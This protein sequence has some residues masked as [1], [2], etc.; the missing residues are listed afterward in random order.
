MGV[1][2]VLGNYKTNIVPHKYLCK[3]YNHPTLNNFCKISFS[4]KDL[5]WRGKHSFIVFQ[6]STTS[7]TWC[8]F[9]MLTRFLF[10]KVYILFA[11]LI[12]TTA[13]GT[14]LLQFTYVLKSIQRFYAVLSA[15]VNILTNIMSAHISPFLQLQHKFCSH[16][17]FVMRIDQMLSLPPLRTVTLPGLQC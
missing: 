11:Q 10:W 5:V 8:Y 3:Q 15:S 7:A 12:V 6:N 9:I 13:E 16:L 4:Q 2:I 14:N 17:R 1:T